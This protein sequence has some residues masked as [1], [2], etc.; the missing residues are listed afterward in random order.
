MRYEKRSPEDDGVLGSGLWHGELSGM[1]VLEGRQDKLRSVSLIGQHAE[2]GSGSPANVSLQATH[3]LETQHTSPGPSHILRVST[4]RSHDRSSASMT[5][6]QAPHKGTKGGFTSM[7]ATRERYQTRQSPTETRSPAR[8]DGRSEASPV[9]STVFGTSCTCILR[10]SMHC[11]VGSEW[12][13]K[14][15]PAAPLLHCPA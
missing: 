15:I 3:C 10:W 12:T 6:S 2:A 9:I 7:T 8:K 13:I 5:E 14:G 4:E 1:R 11:W